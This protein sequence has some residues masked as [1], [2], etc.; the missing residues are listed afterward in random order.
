MS[1]ATAIE[2]VERTDLDW[3]DVRDSNGHLTTYV[4]YDGAPNA[5]VVHVTYCLVPGPQFRPVLTLDRD[6]TVLLRQDE[7]GLPDR[8]VVMKATAVPPPPMLTAGWTA[9]LM[10]YRKASSC[11]S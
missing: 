3:L 11:P 5:G 9:G 4:K 7:P 2:D 1:F 8:I 6:G 10:E